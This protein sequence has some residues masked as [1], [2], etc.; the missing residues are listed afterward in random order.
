[1]A[2]ATKER[3]FRSFKTLVEENPINK[4]TISNITERVGVNRHTFYYHFRDEKDLMVWGITQ[5][6]DKAKAD[7]VKEGNWIDS[8]D[9]LLMKAEEERKFLL[10]LFH[11]HL[12][13]GF[14]EI[15]QTW[16]LSIFDR[17]IRENSQGMNIREQ[18]LQ[19][20]I[21]LLTYGL[22]G[23]VMD[24]L[25][26]GMMDSHRKICEQVRTLIGDS[27]QGVLKQFAR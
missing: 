22:S 23:I 24:W 3:L 26:G 5:N 16:S 1:M 21:K 17:I 14:C 25:A 20:V 8:L 19:F 2:Q 18:D 15:I 10:A 6:L 9:K 7:A 27:F 11:S 13:E 4:I 12:K